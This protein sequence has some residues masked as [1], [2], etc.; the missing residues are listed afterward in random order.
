MY[1]SFHEF[2]TSQVHAMREQSPG[3]D[4][5]GDPSNEM[6]AWGVL[7]IATVVNIDR[8][9][10]LFSPRERAQLFTRLLQLLIQ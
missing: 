6:R 2:I 10:K 8:E 7:G 5:G 4:S 3:G 9:L 1:R